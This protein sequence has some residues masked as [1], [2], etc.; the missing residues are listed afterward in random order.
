[1]KAPKIR[2]YIRDLS[3]APQLPIHRV[4]RPIRKLALA[5]LIRALRDG[6]GRGSISSEGA[7][8]TVYWHQD[9][10]EWLFSESD[11][12]GSFLWICDILAMDPAKLRSWVRT[13]LQSNQARQKATVERL[14]RLR[15]VH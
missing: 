13:F 10:R 15:I 9:A 3:S 4:D 7:K 6:I 2:V 11:Q 14:H 12:A 5:I 8:E 1:M